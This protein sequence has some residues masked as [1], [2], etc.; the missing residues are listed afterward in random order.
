MRGI[1][2]LEKLKELFVDEVGKVD[3]RFVRLLKAAEEEAVEEGRVQCQ[4]LK[5]FF[6]VF[7]CSDL[8]TVLLTCTRAPPAQRTTASVSTEELSKVHTGGGR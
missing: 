3:L 2:N 6:L 5:D 7:L 8:F 4:I 1:N